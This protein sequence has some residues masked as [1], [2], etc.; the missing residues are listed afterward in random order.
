MYLTWG[1]LGEE[2]LS[3]SIL[4]SVWQ[5]NIHLF[6][7]IKNN[8][9]FFLCILLPLQC[10]SHFPHTDAMSRIT[11]FQL[12]CVVKMLLDWR[13][14]ALTFMRI[15]DRLEM[16]ISMTPLRFKTAY[17]NTDHRRYSITYY[18]PCTSHV[19]RWSER[20][21]TPPCLLIAQAAFTGNATQS[22]RNLVRALTWPIAERAA[23]S[24][25]FYAY[26]QRRHAHARTHYFIIAF[27]LALQPALVSTGYFWN[28][29]AL[30]LLLDFV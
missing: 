15:L 8:P 21:A 4:F 20:H 30:T 16:M 28:P 18:T 2:E 26:A 22:L 10:A 17:P 1:N 29:L 12:S 5:D 6:R 27:H 7:D 23:R 11:Q 24:R 25:C 14:L 13:I 9:S 3:A 19:L